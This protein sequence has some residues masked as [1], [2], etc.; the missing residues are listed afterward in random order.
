MYLNYST[1]G[2]ICP[3][4]SS[5]FF[6]YFKLSHQCDKVKGIDNIKYKMQHFV[7]FKKGMEKEKYIPLAA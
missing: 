7:I 4:F 1:I 6:H 2:R 3:H 5:Q